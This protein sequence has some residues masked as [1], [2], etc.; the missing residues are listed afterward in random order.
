MTTT[1]QHLSDY[2]ATLPVVSVHEHH[3]PDDWFAG[4]DLDQLFSSSYVGWIN[5]FHG[6]ITDR[7]VFLDHV[8]FNSYFI[9]A[10][11]GIQAVHGTEP[12]TV[13]SWEAV[14]ATMRRAHAAN[15]RLHIDCLRTHGHYQRAIQDSYWA[16][17]SDNG[18]AEIF[19]PTF[20]VNSLILCHHSE[21]ADHNGNLLRTLLADIPDCFD[22]YL[23]CVDR[24]IAE[25]KAAG[26]VALKSTLAYDRDIAFRLVERRDA[27]RVYGRHP[28]E[29]TPAAGR[30]YQDF[31]H[32]YLCEIAGKYALP[33]QQHTGLA[34]IA[35]SNPMNLEPTIA[36][37]PNTQFILFHGGYPWVAEVGAL[38]HTYPNVCPDLTWLPLISTTAAIRAV[39][40][41]LEVTPSARSIC[42]GGDCWTGEESVG[43]ALALKHT[44]AIALGQLVD[45]GYFRLS[46][47]EAAARNLCYANAQAIYGLP[48]E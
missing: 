43:A 36:R 1:T 14:S 10:E 26:A 46:Q 13:A 40:E 7:A 34:K 4:F 27:A 22:D 45:E 23:L 39:R 8:R 16:P 31:M 32:D 35:G 47:A 24:L 42:W 5:P 6:P 37:H 48:G 29:V 20:R 3:H 11:R 33:F 21:M 41:W 19:S 18:H 15:A 28:S 17:G 9:W 30:M 38:A 2:L 44:L 25:R 12:I